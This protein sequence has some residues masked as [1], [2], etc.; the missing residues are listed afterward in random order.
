MDESADSL[1]EGVVPAL[2]VASLPGLFSDRFVLAR[3][4]DRGVGFPKVAER[5]TPAIFFG[6][7]VPEFPTG[8]CAAISDEE[9]HDLLGTAANG[10]P[11]PPF[12][13]L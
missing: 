3:V 13:R 2:N 12:M 1:P 11:N 6:D 4:D 7:Q 8:V 10:D 9:R 5:S